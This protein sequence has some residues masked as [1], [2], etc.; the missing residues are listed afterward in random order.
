MN[1]LSA[2]GS[3]LLSGWKEAISALRD[4]LVWIFLI[5]VWQ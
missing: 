4:T 5:T 1:I 2:D 3:V